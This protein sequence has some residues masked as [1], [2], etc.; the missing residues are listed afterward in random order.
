MKRNGKLL[1]LITALIAA[2]SLS[3]CGAK[4]DLSEEEMERVVNYAANVLEKHNAL[5]RGT[6]ADVSDTSL[7][8][9]LEE[10]DIMAA[11]EARKAAEREKRKQKEAEDQES[12]EGSE[13]NE[14]TSPLIDPN[15][16]E[17]KSL[18]EMLGIEGFSIDYAGY[19]IK[20][21][22]P[23]SVSDNDLMF[24]I[25]AGNGDTLLILKFNVRNLSSEPAHCSVLEKN[26]SFKLK[27]N[28]DRHSFLT[29]LLM[30]DLATFD[31]DME[32]GEV[33]EAVLIAEI[34]TSRAASIETLVLMLK[35]PE[36]NGQMILQSAP[37]E[38]IMPSEV[39]PAV[40]TEMPAEGAEP[41]EGDNTSE[42]EDNGNGNEEMSSVV[43]DE[44]DA[45]DLPL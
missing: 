14:N 23:E 17:Y 8:I 19:D 32:G 1:I 13:G 3:A 6:L 30:D 38:V 4:L 45:G 28:G 29:T 15:A 24:G 22:Y 35:G 20:D 36:G 2:L 25:N 7:A 5:Q 34:S 18:A 16:I 12:S 43:P 44:I 42:G 10:Q 27:I 37:G 41:V 33:K 9:L 39:P 40:D 11:E 21:S 31:E 26:P